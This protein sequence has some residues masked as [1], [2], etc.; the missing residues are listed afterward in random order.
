[1]A[2]TG[3]QLE[4]GAQPGHSWQ[5]ESLDGGHATHLSK[6]GLLEVTSEVR[7][8]VAPRAKKKNIPAM[9][10]GCASLAASRASCTHPWAHVSHTQ[11]ALRVH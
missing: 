1:M 7:P 3:P 2:E 4:D 11:G 9:S 10:L 5:A 8:P 6:M